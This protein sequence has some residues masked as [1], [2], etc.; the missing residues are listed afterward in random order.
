[1][2][3]LRD[4]TCLPRD[5]S[6][7]GI[8]GALC[9]LA[10]M[11]AV[12]AGLLGTALPRQALAQTPAPARMGHQFWTPVR[13]DS[14]R[15]TME[16]FLLVSD[17]L[18]QTIATY[19]QN[20]SKELAAD[21]SVLSDLLVYMIDLED[22]PTATRR[23]T[24][25]KTFEFLMDIFGRI[26]AP[27]LSELP[28]LDD[29]GAQGIDN[30]RIPQTP[31]RIDRITEGP[32]EGEFLFSGATVRIAPRFY[33]AV[34][35]LPLQS[36]MGIDSWI[37]FG[38]EQT[39]PLVPPFVMRM[40]PD[41]LNRLWL[42][43]P[44]WK[45]MFETF[46]LLLIGALLLALNRMLKRIR[47]VGRVGQLLLRSIPPLLLVYLSV[48]AL[49]FIA[50]QVHLSGQF[51]M[52]YDMALAVALYGAL[53]MLFWLAVRAAVEAIILSPRIME[54][55]L[56][57]GLLRLGSATVG[58][59][60]AMVI[61]ALGG[62]AIGLPVLSVVA[63]LGVGG[64]AMALAVRPT[65]ENLIGGVILFIDRPVR[66]GDFC[67]VGDQRGTVAGIG[68]RSTKLRALDRTIISIPNAQF[69]DMQI[70]N[71]TECD[72]LLINETIALR[73][74]ISAD[75]LRYVLAQLRRMLLAH[76]RIVSDT[77]R[78]RLVGFADGAPHV[79]IRI[80]ADTRD[81]NDF[82]AIR[83]DVLL[84]V[85]DTILDAGTRPAFPSQT[86]YMARDEAPDEERS[87]AAESSVQQWR[88]EGRLPFPRMT[89]AEQEALHGTLD[90]PPTGSHEAGK[91]GP[92]APL[93]SE[94][95]TPPQKG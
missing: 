69:A 68:I 67:S 37:D 56:D 33:D 84:R 32:R 93:S 94:P 66:V 87:T 62:Q 82:Y 31:F 60:G 26:G 35:H 74:D 55:S 7:A 23:E 90:Y 72:Q 79:D 47:T 12:I 5:R 92:A 14:P 28:G 88:K 36:V 57:A 8:A 85:F 52:L 3:R 49:P 50:Y 53:A 38:P 76:P 20:P 34:R 15:E 11:L 71:W 59:I 27:D 25:I 65:F 89:Q 81:W 41:A 63:G 10:M 21:I 6:R 54:E 58:V 22:V 19:I 51:A 83:E 75:Q 39:G 70:V 17:Q 29:V 43:T 40:M 42:E 86:L 78:V 44:A 48:D 46:L 16:S 30:V 9:S 1:M 64:L 2:T 80:Y 61:V 95:G 18:E 77:I 45:V 24:G 73:Q 91:H 4:L 13:T